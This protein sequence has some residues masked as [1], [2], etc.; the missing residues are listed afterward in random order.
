M[1]KECS[2][3]GRSK[4]SWQKG[5]GLV[6][7]ILGYALEPAADVLTVFEIK[8]DEA[9]VV[10]VGKG[11]LAKKTVRSLLDAMTESHSAAIAQ[12]S[13]LIQ[14]ITSKADTISIDQLA[15]L[16]SQDLTTM[17]RLLT[18]ANTLGYNPGGAEV[19]TL[20]QAIQTV[21]FEKIRNVAMALLLLES[22]EKSNVAGEKQSVAAHALASGVVAQSVLERLGGADPEQAFVSAALRSYGQLLLVNFLPDDYLRAKQLTS[23]MDWDCACLEVFGLTSLGVAHDV[24]EA[25]QLSKSLLNTLCPIDHDLLKAPVVPP[26]QVLSMVSDYA[27]RLCD[28]VSKT[29]G[30]RDEMKAE[31]VRLACE[32]GPA[33]PLVDSD[34]DQILDRTRKALGSFGQAYGLQGFKSPLIERLGKQPETAPKRSAAEAPKAPVPKKGPLA[35]GDEL[36]QMVLRLYDPD[37]THSLTLKQALAQSLEILHRELRL[38]QSVV[39]LRE[40]RASAWTA[41]LGRGELFN[42]TRSQPLLS[43]ESRNI[44]TICLTRGEDVIIQSP[45]QPS[46]R[47][48]IPPWLQPYVVGQPLMLLSLRDGA[49]TYG[50]ICAVGEN[51][52]SISLTS[53]FA[54]PLRDL[55]TRFAGLNREEVAA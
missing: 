23:D 4:S 8:M 41:K 24:L 26:T 12:V 28:W 10:A 48:H 29:G 7:W 44:F 3:E 27:S 54:Q 39:F 19:T 16:V 30:S 11:S 50:V 2:R 20:P 13:Q 33:L 35:P 36:R 32:Y 5:E 52:H 18:V 1:L 25:S 22:A 17:T 31:A 49:D 47:K 42:A 53:Q 55:R 21:G 34:M 40:A 37:P 45:D 15:D 51:V 43:A 9:A 6:L 14:A 46:I 38:S